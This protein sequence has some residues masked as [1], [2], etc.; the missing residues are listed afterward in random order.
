MISLP[1]GSNSD[2]KYMHLRTSDAFLASSRRYTSLFVLQSLLGVTSLKDT[3][4]GD[5]DPI[6]F[7][8]L[9]VLRLSTVLFIHS[10]R[11]MLSARFFV[12]KETRG[13]LSSAAQ[14][15]GSV[16]A[17][18]TSSSVPSW[19]TYDPPSLGYA[20]TPYA[21]QNC[22]SGAWQPP[23]DAASSVIAFP[24]PMNTDVPYPIFTI[25]DTTDVTPFVH[26][27]R[28]CP[29]TGLHNPLKNPERYVQLGE[30]SRQV[31][32]ADVCSWN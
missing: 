6:F 23:N 19:A 30:I 7:V 10:S 20:A 1:K 14:R 31:R 13:R 18:S 12:V 9:V 21:V 24:H 4:L 3:F 28:Q 2:N 16:A 22:V 32:F 25:P 17:L 29:K 27:L 5:S 26:S 11:T 8:T 15:I